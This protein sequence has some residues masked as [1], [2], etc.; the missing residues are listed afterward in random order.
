MC[1]CVCV[2]CD[3]ERKQN[4]ERELLLKTGNREAP[5][6]V[7]KTQNLQKSQSVSLHWL[8]NVVGGGEV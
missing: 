4:E 2:F 7:K 8:S 1:V 5:S 6:S 3:D